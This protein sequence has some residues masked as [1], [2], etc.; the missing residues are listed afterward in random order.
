[1]NK[2]INFPPRDRSEIEGEAR[3][4]LMRLDGGTRNRTELREFREW[5]ARSPLHQE[6]FD[7]AAAAWN[8]LDDLGQWLDLEVRTPVRPLLPR[9]TFAV[10]ATL[11]VAALGAWL[12]LPL[13]DSQT[14]FRAEY[15]T[16]IGEVRTVSLPDGTRVQLNTGTRL[17]AAMDHHGRL[18]RLDAGE[19]WF[20]VARDAD[21]PFVVY[22]SRLA[23]RAVGTAFAVRV[24]GK[25][26]NLTVTE[27]HVEIASLDEALPETAELQL[28]RFDRTD[29]RVPLDEGQ[30]VVYDDRIELLSR[31]APP[32]IE[33]NLS[34]RDGMLIFDDDP[35]EQ[36]VAEINRYAR[37]KIV[38]SDAEIQDLRFGGYFRV[39]DISSILATF[40][41]DFGIRVERIN[42]ELVY[43]SRRP[44]SD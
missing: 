34:W 26:V 24:D 17:V 37:Q 31:W 5:L 18:V 16:T 41:E 44:I 43:L 29:S 14:T 21:R 7:Q 15:A 42:E 36:V 2:I 19:A 8:K 27:G 38:I 33:R 1:M 6:A 28:D 12:A 23:V 35:L 9:R 40:E 22:A 4:W 25:R 20:Q 32:E 11:L 3:A 30:H 39:G 13:R 10:A